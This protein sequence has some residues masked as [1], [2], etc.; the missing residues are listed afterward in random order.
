V[1]QLGG[2]NPETVG[3]AT[4]ACVQ[5]GGGYSEINLNCGCPSPRVSKHSFGARLMLDPELVRRIVAEMNRRAGAMTVTV[6]CRIGVDS[7]DSYEELKNFINIV[8]QGGVK[9]FVIHSRKCILKGL[10]PKQNRDVPPLKYEI[11]HRLSQEYPDLKF[12]LNGGITTLAQ[13]KSHITEPYLDPTTNTSLPPVHGVM[14]GRAIW[15]N[16]VMLATADSQF[17]GCKDPGFTRR[18]ILAQ[19]IE[20]CEYIQ[21]DAGPTRVVMR[22]SA[23]GVKRESS[24]KINTSILLNAMR[25]LSNGMA[26]S[27]K[28][29]QALNDLYVE[30]VQ[31]DH[32]L[33]YPSPREIVRYVHSI[34]C[35]IK[36]THFSGCR[37]KERWS[38]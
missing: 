1:I 27:V 38:A 16:P 32:G 26:G 29:K 13:A 21:S 28:F 19:Y 15:S 22:T 37:L 34:D 3:K 17:F 24:Q 12:I 10:T 5:Y 6:K 31:R 30:R 25:N 36:L 8:H 20:H 14:I 18:E 9:K 33:L 11:V 4:E 23:G 35:L 7:Q 2:N